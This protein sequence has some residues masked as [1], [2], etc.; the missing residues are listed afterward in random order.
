[1]TTGEKRKVRKRL[2]AAL[3]ELFV[4]GALRLRLEGKTRMQNTG[5]RRQKTS[6]ER[7]KEIPLTEL[8]QRC[9]LRPI[10]F[11]LGEPTRR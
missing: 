8:T 9:S 10:G 5:V 1:V 7:K 4:L 6:G 3:K 11:M 2:I